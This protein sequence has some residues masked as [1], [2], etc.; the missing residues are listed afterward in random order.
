[1]S[2]AKKSL[3]KVLS[4]AFGITLILFAFAAYIMTKGAFNDWDISDKPA[5]AA[6]PGKMQ[7]GDHVT[8]EIR[9]TVGSFYY[10]YSSN[11]SSIVLS[12]DEGD[13]VEYYLVPILEETGENIRFTKMI[14]VGSNEKLNEIDE[15]SSKFSVW[16]NDVTNST[17]KPDEVVCVVDGKVEAMSESE[18]AKLRDYF[19]DN[20]GEMSPDAV[21]GDLIVK[22]LWTSGTKE[23]ARTMIYVIIG[24]LVVGIALIVFACIK[25]KKV[26]TSEQ[27]P[28]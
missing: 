24:S 18:R 27:P 23:N 25:R 6:E 9:Y 13:R 4:A 17:P 16:W 20:F 8:V 1:M 5:Y 14:A 15:A 7:E 3:V 10:D 22:P 2:S 12:S 26:S 28:Q 21:V 11:K 19:Y